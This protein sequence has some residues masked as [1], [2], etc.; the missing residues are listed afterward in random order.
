MCSGTRSMKTR[1]P[2]RAHPGKLAGVTAGA[3]ILGLLHLPDLD[4][5]GHTLLI[6]DWQAA[7]ARGGRRGVAQAGPGCD[8]LLSAQPST[9]Q[10]GWQTGASPQ[11]LTSNRNPAQ[12]GQAS[13]YTEVTK[14]W[15][16]QDASPC[17]SADHPRA[18]S[19]ASAAV[20]GPSPPCSG[21]GTGSLAFPPH[22]ESS[23]R[24]TSPRR[25]CP[26]FLPA[27]PAWHERIR[28]L[29]SENHMS[30]FTASWCGSWASCVASLCLS[31]LLCNTSPPLQ[32]SCK[33]WE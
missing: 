3:P 31:F 5:S 13:T 6:L 20:T 2:A 8:S 15:P 9:K 26:G 16:W 24:S 10:R 27:P 33:D 12:S 29:Q 22:T 30:V 21:H 11:P 1:V 28:A 14:G 25:P 17:L 18:Q 23:M 32:D 19:P 7:H 4:P